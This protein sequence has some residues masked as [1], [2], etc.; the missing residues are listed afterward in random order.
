[1]P[2]KPVDPKTYWAEYQEILHNDGEPFF[3]RGVWK[4]AV[5]SALVL[6]VI[7]VLAV[8]LGA[9][10]LGAQ[11]DPTTPANPKPDWYL[12]WYFAIL[13]LVGVDP[14]GAAVTPFLII[15]APAVGFGILFLIPLANKGERHYARRPWA[16][17]TVIIAATSTAILIWLGYAEPW[18][19]QLGTSGA[20]VP[21]LPR[22]A[23]IHLSKSAQRGAQ[24]MHA[25]ACLACHKISSTGGAPTGIAQGGPPGGSGSGGEPTGAVG[26]VRGPDLTYVGDRLTEDQFIYRILRGG[27]GMPAYGNVLTPRE[28]TDMV[29]F[30]ETRK[31]NAGPGQAASG[32]T[33]NGG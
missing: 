8:T 19:P 9:Q 12:I 14:S 4:D 2:G 1:V 11:A 15:L 17:A 22:Y 5:M 16:V 7:L 26:G 27:G 3:P 25:E 24:L 23:Y 13:A 29:N 6:V 32:G 10:D 18:K 33:G 28:L 30:L 21:S 20:T 31:Q